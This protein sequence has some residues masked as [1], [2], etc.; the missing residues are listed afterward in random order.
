M[1][2]PNTLERVADL[3]PVPESADL[4]D[5]AME[6][7]RRKQQ[8]FLDIVAVAVA[9]SVDSILNLRLEPE[10][11]SLIADA[12][13][14]QYPQAEFASLEGASAEQLAGWAN[15]IKGKYFE[16]LV[17]DRLNS[18]ESVGELVLGPGQ[19]AIIA[20]SPTQAGWDLQISNSADG[21][22]VELLQL[23]ATESLGYVR[24][25]LDR[26]PG[27]RVATTSDIDRVAG[28][29][30]QTDISDAELEEAVG[31]Y[32]GELSEDRVTDVLNQGAEWAFDAIPVIPAVVVAITEGR[33]VFVGRSDMETALS[34]GARRIGKAATFSIL[35]ATL[36]AL[37]TGLL[38]V[39]ATAAARV[40]WSR[41]ANRIALGEFL[42][43]RTLQIQAS[44]AQVEQGR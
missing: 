42:E 16:V 36:A 5:L 10:S 2:E 31:Q 3:Y 7:E 24:S 26:Y 1:S 38:S 32:V 37:N 9:V 20:E 29:T 4:T 12:F 18:G 21:S 34:D 11:D 44:T 43:L 23:K 39:P 40:V 41:V 27:I 28:Q 25:A 22:T 19:V 33:N 30:L 35:G 17:A 14:L 13:R 6:Y 8:E 15:G